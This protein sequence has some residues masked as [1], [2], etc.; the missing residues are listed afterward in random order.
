MPLTLFVVL[1]FIIALVGAYGIFIERRRLS[2]TRHDVHSTALPEGFHGKTIVQFSDTH[3]GP[4][5]SLEHLK[6]L[7]L[8]I[9]SLHPD[10]V[11]FT[12]DLFD[13]RYKDIAKSYDPTMILA[14]I[15]ASLGKYAVYGNH[16]FGYT[17]KARNSGSHLSHA[18]F[19]VL[20]NEVDRITLPNGEYI[21]V[22]GL[23]DYVN[24]KP[25]ANST[26]SVRNGDGFHLLLAHEPDIAD[27]LVRY[28]IDLQLSGHSHGGQVTLPW[29]GALI[30][31]PLGKKYISGMYQI[32]K[33]SY[34]DRPYRLYV[35]RGIGTTRIPIRI[36]CVPELSVFTLWRSR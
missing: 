9:N 30:K 36:G 32:K 24:G 1:L 28:P 20:I 16:D 18:G 33:R 4:Q 26:F 34:D 12:G 19:K 22:A 3:I 14:Q 23:D 21:T 29:V 11:V 5:Y 27:R 6:Q 17:R 2:I 25:N 15:N 8:H 31:T 7:I 10:I 35:N 13:A